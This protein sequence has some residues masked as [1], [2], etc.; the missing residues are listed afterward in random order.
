MEAGNAFLEAFRNDYNGK[1]SVE[2]RSPHDVHRPLLSTEDLDR[3]ITWSEMRSVS[4]QLTLQYDKVLYLIDPSA[5]NQ[6]L[7]GKRVMVV[8]FPDG[9]IQLE[10]EGR[11]LEYREFD[12]LAQ[13]H[14]AEVTDR[15]RLGA[16]L[17]FA[18]AEQAKLPRE[19]RSVKCPTRSYPKP[20]ERT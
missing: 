6:K 8:D 13:V 7:A 4:Q 19:K 11:I 3:I 12:K 18:K 16:M 17:A 15:K 2:P 14:Q 10:Y 9:R 1:F 20:S 5:E